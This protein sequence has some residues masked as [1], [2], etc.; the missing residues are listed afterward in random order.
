MRKTRPTP[1]RTDPR[2]DRDRRW[3]EQHVLGGGDLLVYGRLVE[4]MEDSPPED[5]WQQ[6]R[7]AAEPYLAGGA[8]RTAAVHRIVDETQAALTARDQ[9]FGYPPPF[10]HRGCSNCCHEVVYCT[11]E[12]ARLIHGFCRENGIAIDRA[13]LERQLRF[14]ETDANL[15]HTGGTTWNDQEPG[16]QACA[17]LDSRDG[18]CKVW[19][20]RPLVCRVHLAE[21]TDAHCRPHNGRED[22]EARG[23]SYLELSYILSAIFTIHRDSIRRTLG[24][25]LLG[26]EG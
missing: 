24:R 17:F 4:D 10:C 26:L 8:D 12:E 22:P 18:S 3:L 25:L 6:L 14:I 7:A 16:D 1:F 2:Q 23:I 20:V 9:R 19:P 11:S 15:D 21:G 13:R 5:L